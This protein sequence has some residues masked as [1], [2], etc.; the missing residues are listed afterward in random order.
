M[1]LIDVEIQFKPILQYVEN[2]GKDTK[3]KIRV[4]KIL[5]NFGYRYRLN[6][7]DLLGKPDIF[8]INRNK[9]IFV[10]GCFWHRH[11]NCKYTTTPKPTPILDQKIPRQFK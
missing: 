8:I 1:H 11:R 6:S 2:P 9:I 10:H 7:K 5:W 3:P 4:R